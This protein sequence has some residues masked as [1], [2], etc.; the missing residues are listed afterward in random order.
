MLEVNPINITAGEQWA[1]EVLH[2]H[3]LPHGWVS[4]LSLLVDESEPASFAAMDY[5]AK[6]SEAW[7]C[8][9]I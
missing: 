5:Q 3:G 7:S 1:L 6:S 8:K 2:L 9:P 4:G